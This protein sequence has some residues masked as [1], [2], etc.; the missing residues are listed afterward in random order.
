MLVLLDCPSCKLSE[1]QK[2]AWN[3]DIEKR[4]TY[5]NKLHQYA[6][7]STKCPQCGKAMKIDVEL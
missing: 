5:Q 6:T 7:V 3:R 4:A 1:D 2:E